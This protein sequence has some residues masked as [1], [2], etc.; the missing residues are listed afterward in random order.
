MTVR[1]G[2]GFTILPRKVWDTTAR[3]GRSR[4]VGP[5]PQR[6]WPRP[7]SGRVEVSQPAEAQQAGRPAGPI[8]PREHALEDERHVRGPLGQAPHVPG[9]PVLAV[10]DEHAER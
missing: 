1:L 6:E 4:R 5:G 7:G 8:S 2:R 10:A 3:G 9:E